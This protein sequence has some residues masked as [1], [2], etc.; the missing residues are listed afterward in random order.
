MSEEK[1]LTTGIPSQEEQEQVKPKRSYHR[2]TPEEIAAD[3]AAKEEKKR[4][5]AAS[6]DDDKPTT[7]RKKAGN[8]QAPVMQRRGQWSDPNASMVFEK[9]FVEIEL[10]ENALG[11]WP[12]SKQLL[13]EYIASNAPDRASMEEEITALGEE[14]I[15][16]KQT[17]V[18]PRGFFIK[19]DSRYIDVI[20]K[21]EGYG[22]VSRQDLEEKGIRLPFIFDYQLR[23]M[24]KDTCGLLARGSYGESATISAYK[25]VIDGAYSSILAG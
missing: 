20:D 7:K 21:R 19:G 16:K 9:M 14:A 25:K 5:K 3:K 6:K 22:K 8:G 12:N 23:G 15:E 10:L 13:R 24:F 2:R 4:A 17:T 11:T 1:I 18:F